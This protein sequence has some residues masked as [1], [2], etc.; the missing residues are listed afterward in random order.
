M[1]TDPDVLQAIH[2]VVHYV[3]YH[4]T[5]AI[6]V[7]I[8]RD[9]Y[10]YWPFIVST[11]LIAAVAIRR[12]AGPGMGGASGSWRHV[13]GA[14]L[15]WHPSSRADYRLYFAN[16]LVLPLVLSPL[17]FSDDQFAGWASRVLGLE[18][19]AS[20][21]TGAA[22]AGGRLL[23]SLAFFVAYDFGRFVAHSLL[24]D[25]PF[26]WPFHKVHHSAQVLTPI[27]AFRVHPVDLLVMAWVPALAT[28]L[29][30]WLFNRVTDTPV[31]VY[32]FLGLHVLIWA[33]NL[34]DNLRHSP[35][36]LT[37]GPTLGK[38]LLSPA[39]HQLHH[40]Y[41]PRHMGCNRG[42]DIALWDRLWGTLYV[43]SGP[44]EQFRM[45]LGDGSDGEWNGL[46][47]LYF[48]PFMEAVQ[49]LT[50]R[51]K[52]AEPDSGRSHASAD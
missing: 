44:P 27:T 51:R 10:L 7:P 24:H 22:D 37:Y 16:A 39:H 36:W 11:A 3:V 12:L 46:M 31:S 13:L 52:A 34:I 50:G 5:R 15:W 28:G 30:T 8:Q 32:T 38:W 4:L 6:T 21:A 29:T 42:F 9:S 43:P 20:Q 18:S 40:S 47:K 35:V 19:A 45:G 33:F 17:Q 26:L 25:V 49:V 14:R 23:F 48:R 41:E 2:G 1:T